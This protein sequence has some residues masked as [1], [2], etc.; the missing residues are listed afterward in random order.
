MAT[1]EMPEMLT[2]APR[3]AVEELEVA[4]DR[5]AVAREAG[6][7]L[8]LHLVEVEREVA[9]GALGAARRPGRGAAGRRS[10]G[11]TRVTETCAAVAMPTGR[12]PSA[13]RKT[14]ESKLRALVAGLRTHVDDAV[15]GDLARGR[16]PSVLTATM[17]SSWRYWS[18]ATPT[19]NSSGCAAS[20]PRTRPRFVGRAHA[21]TPWRWKWTL[22]VAADPLVVAEF[23]AEDGFEGA[24]RVEVLRSAGVPHRSR[25]R[26]A[27]GA[28]R[29]GRRA[30]PPSAMPMPAIVSS[31]TMPAS[32][33]SMMRGVDE[34]DVP[35]V[36]GVVAGDLEDG[37][38]GTRPQVGEDA[39]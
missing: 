23:V 24:H 17:S 7:E 34:A 10:S 22:D 20:T 30:A 21:A 28:A 2:W 33:W 39:E 5:L 3:G 4:V 11:S 13:S 38:A 29:S 19:Q 25:T 32:G 9:L 27:G 16:G 8:A 37:G 26:S 15:E 12:T 35:G 31:R 14:S 6:G 18:S 1:P 36:D